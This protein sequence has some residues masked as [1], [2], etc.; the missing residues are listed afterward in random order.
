MT[1]EQLRI[2]VKVVQS[3]SFTRAADLL[4]TQKSY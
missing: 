4:G 1:L 2:L 3:G